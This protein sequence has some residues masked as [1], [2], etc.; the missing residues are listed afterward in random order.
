MDSGAHNDYSR[1]GGTPTW[2]LQADRFDA[3]SLFSKA[4]PGDVMAWNTG[5]IPAG[6]VPMVRERGTIV[7][8]VVEPAGGSTPGGGPPLRR[9]MSAPLHPCNTLIETQALP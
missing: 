1:P 9:S 7:R 4:K 3:L 6:T 8:A 2:L 5:S